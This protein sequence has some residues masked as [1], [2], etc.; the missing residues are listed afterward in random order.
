MLRR[1]PAYTPCIYTAQAGL[2][3][4]TSLYG[5]NVTDCE[6]EHGLPGGPIRG[7]FTIHGPANIPLGA[8]VCHYSGGV[9]VF[10]GSVDSFE[11]IGTGRAR[12]TVVEVAGSVKHMQEDDSYSRFAVHSD[13]S[14]WKDHRSF[15]GASP[16]TWDGGFS[17][18]VSQGGVKIFIPVGKTAAAST[19]GRITLD[20]GPGNTIKR[21]VVTYTGGTAANCQLNMYGENTI[22]ALT[23]NI[24]VDA[25]PLLAGPTTVGTSFA[26]AGFR[27]AGLALVAISSTA[28]ATNAW[29]NI[30]SILVFTSTAYESANASILTGD[31]VMKDVLGAGIT[32]QISTDTSR[33][34]ALPT[35]L[36]HFV[37]DGPISPYD[38]FESAN[39]VDQYQWYLDP[40]TAMPVA[41]ARA[42][43]TG[44]HYTAPPGTYKM[45]NGSGYA[46]ADIYN[47]VRIRWREANGTEHLDTVTGSSDI[48]TRAG[49]TRTA[50]IEVTRPTTSTEATAVANAFLAAYANPS[51]RG[52]S[53]ILHQGFVVGRD[54]GVEVPAAR[55]FV[56]DRLE[57][58]GERA[59]G[60]TPGYRGLI[61]NVKWT[62]DAGTAEIVLENDRM[63]WDRMFQRF[64]AGIPWSKVS[65]KL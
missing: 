38:L 36:S 25:A 7:A 19:G 56:G 10:T 16:T 35:A 11:T 23:E 49:K 64:Q 60:S 53:V 50:T 45:G 30:S 18:V 5:Y 1:S 32:P 59:P 3:P 21:V 13:M 62:Q 14:A 65:G 26:A 52:G 55:L 9:P 4:V 8:Q 41:V 6:H 46:Q 57:L 42:I 24:A 28:G 63:A 29:I 33:I 34:A 12:Q 51:L 54:S 31:V 22:D 20:A 15:P 61:Q 37:S 17:V 48:L 58:P 39:A 44:V 43:P 27:Y 40:S 2:A 47:K